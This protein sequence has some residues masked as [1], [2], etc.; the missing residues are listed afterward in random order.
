MNDILFI[1]FVNAFV[2]Y[3]WMNEIGIIIEY[4]RNMC[5]RKYWETLD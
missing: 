4:S 3:C 1:R 2:H 5:I